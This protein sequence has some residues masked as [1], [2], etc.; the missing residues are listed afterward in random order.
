MGAAEGSFWDHLE[1]FR[2]RLIV[3]LAAVAVC[4]MAAFAFSG[5]LMSLV[6]SLS[7]CDLQTLSPY[8]AI[9]AS[10]KLS[11]AAGL[12]AASPVVSWQAWRFL[13]PGLYPSERRMLLAGLAMAAVLFCCGA[14]FSLLV[15]LKPTLALFRSFESGIVTG[16]WTLSNFM[17]FIVQFVLVFGLC[18]ELPL[19]V[20]L[21]ARLGIVDPSTLGRYRRHVVIGLL[22]LGAIL[23]P[24]DPLTQVLLAVPLYILYE[25]SVLAA[26]AMNAGGRRRPEI[27]S[28]SPDP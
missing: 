24:N 12:A 6:L 2:R 25:L 19:V 23:P 15:L 28:G 21:L 4:A 11:M 3:S 5:R 9:T 20:L 8:E 26:K 22:V 17:S 14:A 7:P 13:A 16:N 18:F 10:I 1:E 27:R